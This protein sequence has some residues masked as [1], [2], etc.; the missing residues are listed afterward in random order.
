MSCWSHFSYTNYLAHPCYSIVQESVCF[1]RALADIKHLLQHL[2][3]VAIQGLLSGWLQGAAFTAIDE[4]GL[5]CRVE[6]D[7]FDLVGVWLELHTPNIPFRAL[8]PTA[9]LTFTSFPFELSLEPRHSKSLTFFS[10]VSP[11]A[12]SEVKICDDHHRV[13]LH[14]LSVSLMPSSCLTHWFPSWA[15]YQGLWREGRGKVCSP[16]K[17]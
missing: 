16:A 4:D 9:L 6:E 11:D 7:E 13:G 14:L 2:S 5:Y 1:M 8:L 15:R 17:P 10:T 3:I 12:M